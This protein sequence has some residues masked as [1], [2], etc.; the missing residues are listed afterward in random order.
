MR[1]VH[2]VD[3]RGTFQPHTRT[4]CGLDYYEYLLEA[5]SNGDSWMPQKG[6]TQHPIT[7]PSCISAMGGKPQFSLL[8]A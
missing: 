5:T 7:C 2:S 8:E 3:T 6:T 1:R 4:A